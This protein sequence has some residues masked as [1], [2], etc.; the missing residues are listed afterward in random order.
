MPTLRRSRQSGSTIA[1]LALVLPLIS[2]LFFGTTSLG[3]MIGRYVQAVQVTRDVCHM[4][5]NGVDFTQPVPRNIV[6]QRL[7]SGTGMTD[8]G[9]NGVII[10]SKVSTVYLADCN[11]AGYSSAQCVNQNQPVFVNRVYIGNQSLR[12]SAFGTPSSSILGSQ[13][14]IPASVY[15]R[16]TDSSVRANGF[17]SVYGEAVRRATG[18]APAPPAMQ[19]GEVACVAEGYFQYPDIS[20]LQRN[21]ASGAFRRFIFRCSN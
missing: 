16:N 11:A 14:N 4:Y 19:Q 2:V 18:V 17:E 6:T 1:E 10:L 15:M 21:S 12:S 3:I 9:G 13:G 8:T 20:F 7:A 5:S